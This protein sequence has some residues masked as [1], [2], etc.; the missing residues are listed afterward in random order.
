MHYLSTEKKI[1][2]GDL[3][4]K[5]GKEA[6]FRPI[7]G[8]HSFHETTND[9]GL[10]LI[11]FVIGND[12]AAKSTMI[13]HK[14]IYKGTWMSPDGRYVIQIDHILV[15]ARFKN[16]IQDIRTMRKADGDSD[17]YLVKGKIKVKIK[18]VTRKKGTVVD[19]YD[20]AKL[21]NVNTRKRFKYL[22]S[23]KIRRIDTGINNSNDAKWKKIKVTIKVV[24][25]S[26]IGKLKT[27]RKPWFNDMCENA[28]NRRKEA[29]NQWLND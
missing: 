14:N 11:D 8:N 9:N 26:E 18:K 13:P 28:L 25:E 5:I 16:C 2:L 10:R 23:E 3:N 4:T 22:M 20:T 27:V 17:H 7:I 29:R 1:I 6:V 21:N 19:K 12:L 15:S 24:I